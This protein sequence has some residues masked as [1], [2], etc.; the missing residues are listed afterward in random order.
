MSSL[1]HKAYIATL[2]CCLLFLAFIYGVVSAIFHLSPAPDIRIHAVNAYG[3]LAYLYED[4]TDTKNQYTS[5]M[6]FEDA[7]EPSG[8]IIHN[9]A[10][11]QPGLTL[12][13]KN[14]TAAV[15]M[16]S[17]GNI[18]H[19]WQCDFAE[20]FDEDDFAA[21]PQQPDMLHW[22]R[23]HLYPNGDLLANH[24]YVNH[25]PYGYGLVK[26]DKNSQVIWKYTGTAHHDFD[27]DDQ[28]NIYT[29][30]QEI[31]TTPIGNIQPPYIE[32]FAVVIDGVT[33]QEKAA[34]FHLPRPEKLAVS[35]RV[36]PLADHPPQRSHPHQRHSPNPA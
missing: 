12:V 8:A 36:R 15:L 26:L 33:G 20:A 27:F 7:S 6:W 29:L 5:T 1:F 25:Y 30:V 28:G 11:M 17:L 4:L 18:L 22:H 24:D 32:D 23:T 13:S 19:Q 16:D 34:L 3:H 31:G 35:Q 14:A 10:A 21:F 2:I 9:A